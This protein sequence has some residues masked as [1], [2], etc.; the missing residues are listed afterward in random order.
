[1]SIIYR[2]FIAEHAIKRDN[3]LER[4][5]LVHDTR[6]HAILDK[7]YWLPDAATAGECESL[8]KSE[9]GEHV[10]IIDRRETAI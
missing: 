6:R 9:L 7:A 4:L 8:F 10:E 5:A 2:V 3:G 1:M